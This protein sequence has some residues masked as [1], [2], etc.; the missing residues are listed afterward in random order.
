MMAFFLLLWLLGATTEKQRKGIADYFAPTLI[1]KKVDRRSAATACSAANRSSATT[2][3]GRRPASAPDR[4]DRHPDAAVGRAEERHGRQGV[5]AQPGR[6]ATGQAGVPGDQARAGKADQGLA[7]PRASSP[8][9]SA[10]CRRRTACASIWSTT[11]IIRCSRSA[12]PRSIRKASELIGMIAGTIAGHAEHDHD[13]RP[14]RQRALW[15]SARDEQLDAVVG[16]GRGDA[17]AAGAGRHRRRR[18]SSGSRASPT[19]NRSSPTIPATRATAA[20]RSPCSIARA[21]SASRPASA[22]RRRR[23]TERRDR[24]RAP[25][26]C[27]P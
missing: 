1:D 18:G 8:A 13:P 6:A 10:S 15:R 22:C 5:A 7:E 19:A 9:I 21:R 17:P 11:P 16:P 4:V 14:Y 24:G 2:S 25:V 26:P 3:S 12:R 27:S 20:S 23:A